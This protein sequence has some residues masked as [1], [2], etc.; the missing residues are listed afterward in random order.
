MSA[1]LYGTPTVRRLPGDEAT[2]MTG[3]RSG[4]IHALLYTRDQMNYLRAEERALPRHH[5]AK[6]RAIMAKVDA[7]AKVEE[8]INTAQLDCDRVLKGHKALA[9][10]DSAHDR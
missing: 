2:R 6:R 10:K 3:A 8:R 9:S 4:L 7:L 1:D 5:T